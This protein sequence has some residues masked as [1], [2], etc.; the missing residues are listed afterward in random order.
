LTHPHVV[1]VHDVGEEDG[2]PYIVM[3]RLPGAG[4]EREMT[5]GPLDPA[6]ARQVGDGILAALGAAHAAGLIHRDVKPAN[7]LLAAD[8]AVKVADFGI[9]KA[10]HNPDGGASSELDVTGDGQL[11][12]TVAYMAPERIGG[13]PAGVPSDLYS[14]GVILYEALSGSKPF[15]GDTPMSLCWAVHHGEHEPLGNRRPDLDPGLVAV[16]ERAMAL[17]PEDRFVTAAEMA[18]AL[19]GAG[20]HGRSD[21]APTISA[22]PETRVLDHD[23]R[24][25]PPG[26]API[27]APAPRWTRRRAV[28]AI[29]ACL[30]F[31]AAW[32]VSGLEEGGGASAS[33]PAGS[34]PAPLDDALSDLEEAVR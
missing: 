30:S 17:R 7:V 14:V 25:L 21:S 32:F 19:T 23:P 11:V 31:I 4:L 9:A 3:E 18:A 5:A 27:P 28:V 20:G 33:P 26:P 13:A 1:A 34:V 22:G 6:R 15:A 8:G 10:L 2:V 29:A 12:G 24:P 16:I